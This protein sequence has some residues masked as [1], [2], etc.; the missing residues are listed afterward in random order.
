M[1]VKRRVD[2]RRQQYP[3]AIIRL[4]EG[5]PVPFTDEA[6]DAIFNLYF[7]F[8][9]YP[10]LE[11]PGFTSLRRRTRRI[12]APDQM[13]AMLASAPR[14]GEVQDAEA[15]AVATPGPCK[16]RSATARRQAAWRRRVQ[17]RR[18]MVQVEIGESVT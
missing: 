13:T 17:R 9:E 6:E 16:E 14:H 10:E 11:R 3:E 4:I 8:N 1:P 5:Y 2:K 18:M 12:V 15:Q 7:F